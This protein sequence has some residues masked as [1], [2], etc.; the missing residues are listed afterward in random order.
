ML[1]GVGLTWLALEYFVFFYFFFGPGAIWVGIQKFM[2]IG[3]T[4]PDVADQEAVDQRTS[5]E[6]EI[7]NAEHAAIKTAENEFTRSNNI[8]DFINKTVVF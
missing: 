8:D 3:S 6:R 2:E 1:V 4:P 7:K 5:M